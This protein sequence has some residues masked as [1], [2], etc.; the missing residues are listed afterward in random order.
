GDEPLLTNPLSEKRLPETLSVIRFGES[1]TNDYFPITID[2][3]QS[4]LSFTM[5]RYRDEFSVLLLGRHNV[6]N[7]LAA[8]ALED[9]LQLNQQEIQSGLNSLEVTGMRME[10]IP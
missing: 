10:R 2:L 7:V 5:N 3:N 8:I 4:S 6:L 9:H 1:N